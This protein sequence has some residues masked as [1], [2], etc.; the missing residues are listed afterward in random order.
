[1]RK[2]IVCFNNNVDR[3]IMKQKRQ[4][5]SLKSIGFDGDYFCFHSFDEIESKHHSE[6]PYQFKPKAIQKVREMGYDVVL[7]MDS[8]VYATKPLDNVFYHIINN[9]ILLF[10]NIGFTIGDFTSDRCLNITNMT[11]EESFM[12]PMVMACVMGFD[13]R[14]QL[15]NHIFDEYLRLSEVEG[16]F[17]GSWHNDRLQLSNDYRVRGHR[18]DQ[19]VISILAVKY[20]IRLTHPNSTYFA[21]FNNA[22]HLPHANTVCLLSQ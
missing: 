1:M 6:V 19:S 17:E 14:N 13:F 8:P 12:N 20:G 15:T 10:D 3:Y 16:A 2:A 4:E 9:G 21:Y 11:R 22:G 18:H 5:E 7:W